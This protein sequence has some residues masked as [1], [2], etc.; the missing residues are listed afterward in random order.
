M[1]GN[2]SGEAMKPRSFWEVLGLILLAQVIA[3]LVG[4]WLGTI[5]L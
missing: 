3:F 1:D 4:V 2:V 5:T